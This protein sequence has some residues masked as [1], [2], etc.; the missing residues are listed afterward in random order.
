[1]KKSVRLDYPFFRVHPDV[2]Y[3]D[4]A[5][6]SH[7][8]QQVIDVINQFYTHQYANIGRGTYS[9][10]E[11]ATEQYEAV[12][13]VVAQFINAKSGNEIVFTSGATESINLVAAAWAMEHVG[14]DDRIVITELEHHA[15]LLPWQ[16]VAHKRNA[17]LSYIPIADN[18]T[19]LLSQLDTIITQKT[20]LVAVTHSSNAIGTS[21]NLEPIIKRA[22]AVGARVLVDA[23]QSIAHERIDVQL[24]NC[25]FLV[26]SGHKIGAPTGVGVLYIK[27][28]IHSEMVPFKQGGGMVF[29]AD[30]QRASWRSVPH[31]LEAGTPPI[32]Q[33]VGLGAAV[34]YYNQNI[35]WGELLLQESRL[36]AFL[37]NGLLEN[38]AIRILGPID[39]LRQ[40]GHLVSFLYRGIHAHDVAAFLSERGICVRAGNHCAQPLAKRLGYE[41][42]V[43]ASLYHYSTQIEVEALLNALSALKAYF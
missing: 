33:V 23:A 41:A 42:S 8:P 18:G 34:E 43:R 6:T 39:D 15:N 19:L 32:A 22:H 5:S 16:E 38:P 4:N 31:M 14:I 29:E 2:V 11:A 40:K 17:Q 24:M 1:M 7:K 9:F 28:S 25:D 26:F 37:I 36:V 21:I 27:K 35:D 13:Q 10:A 30:Y 12:R 3:L 20:K